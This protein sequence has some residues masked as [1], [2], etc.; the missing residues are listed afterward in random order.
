MLRSGPARRR[1]SSRT[2]LIALLVFNFLA[3]ALA[4]VQR[5]ALVQKTQ[6]ASEESERKLLSFVRDHQKR[7]EEFEN[8][9]ATFVRDQ[10]KIRQEVEASVTALSKLGQDPSR[11]ERIETVVSRL[12][13]R[14]LDMQ[15]SVGML[16]VLV[17][18]NANIDRKQLEARVIQRL[19]DGKEIVLHFDGSD[20]E[21]RDTDGKI[22]CGPEAANG[23]LGV[24]I[25]TEAYSVR[26][27]KETHT[28]TASGPVQSFPYDPATGNCRSQTS[29]FSADELREKIR[30][31]DNELVLWGARFRFDGLNVYYIDRKVGY[32]T[33]FD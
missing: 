19:N 3:L 22:R 26:Y 10:T 21:D 12:N 6:Q 20:D 2:I 33:W 15:R 24:F 4:E 29:G 1:I 7:R 13:Q 18:D 23:Y 14:I 9:I 30:P 32:V 8:A 28:W 31:D 25:A 11:V 5:R 16:Q 17:G 27:D